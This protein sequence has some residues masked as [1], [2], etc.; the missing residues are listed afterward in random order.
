[1]FLSTLL[2][3]YLAPD[4]EGHG[5]EKVIEALHKRSGKFAAPVVP[6]KLIATIFTLAFSVSTFLKGERKQR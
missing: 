4:A 3:K 2:I 6:A 1:M 5:T